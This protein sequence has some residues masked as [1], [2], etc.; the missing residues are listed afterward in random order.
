[1]SSSSSAAVVAAKEAIAVYALEGTSSLG[2]PRGRLFFDETAALEFV[3]AA[4]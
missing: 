4:Q 2:H 1:M 3:R